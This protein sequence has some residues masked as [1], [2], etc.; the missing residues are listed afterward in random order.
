ML[1]CLGIYGEFDM[2]MIWYKNQTLI[3]FCHYS[4]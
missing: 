4:P 2:D 3:E 1:L